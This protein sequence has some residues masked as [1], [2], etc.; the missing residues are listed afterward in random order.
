MVASADNLEE[1]VVEALTNFF[2]RDVPINGG[3][4]ADAAI[5]KGI[6]YV[7]DNTQVIP[8]GLAIAVIYSKSQLKTGNAFMSGFAN[9]QKSG[10]ATRIREF[11]GEHLRVSR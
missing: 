7:Y 4:S 5:N 9:T 3:S 6:R 8:K 11:T 10:K 1:K 2:G